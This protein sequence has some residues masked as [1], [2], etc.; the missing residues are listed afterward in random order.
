MKTIQLFFFGNFVT[1]S[2]MPCEVKRLLVKCTIKNTGFVHRI[3][4]LLIYINQNLQ[5]LGGINSQVNLYWL[6]SYLQK[7][8]LIFLAFKLF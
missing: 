1:I 4:L 3:I 2:D 8:S 5:Y 6:L 7:R